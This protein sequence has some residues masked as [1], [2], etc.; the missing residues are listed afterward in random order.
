VFSIAKIILSYIDMKINLS[1]IKE[2][3]KSL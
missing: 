1:P 2:A 3:P